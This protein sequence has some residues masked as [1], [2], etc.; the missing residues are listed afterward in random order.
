VYHSEETEGF[1]YDCY[2][3]DGIGKR[4]HNSAF[5]SR[6]K[7]CDKSG[8]ASR[9]SLFEAL[10]PARFDG[11][12]KGGEVY[13]FLGYEYVYE[14]GEAMGKPV[15]SPLIRIMATEEEQTGNTYDSIYYN[16]H[17]DNGC[18]LSQLVAHGMVVNKEKILL[19]WQGEIVISTASAASKDGGLE[20]FV[21]FDESHRYNNNAL[22]VMHGVVTNNVTKRRA[23]GSWYLETT[24]MFASGEDSIAEK[25]YDYMG[26]ILEG[27]AKRPK[28]LFDH[29]WG[30]ITDAEMAD[31][32]LL[33]AALI[34]SY[35][36]VALLYDEDGNKIGAGWVDVENIIDDIYTPVNEDAKNPRRFF[37]N[38]P[39][40]QSGNSW[41]QPAELEKVLTRRPVEKGDVITLGFDGSL[42]KDA[43]VLMGCRVSDNY[44]F[45]IYY[46][47]RPD[48]PEAEGWQVDVAAFEGKVDE[49]FRNYRVVGF[50]AD[51]AHW[52]DSIVKWEQKY[53]QYLK[54]TAS[55]KDPIKFY[56]TYPTQ[57]IRALD[58]LKTAI[59][60]CNVAIE[61]NKF[62]KRQ[63]LN[64]IMRE[65][66]SGVLVYKITPKSPRTIDTIY[67]ATFAHE[68]AARFRGTNNP[69]KP[70][71]KPVRR[72]LPARLN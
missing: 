23:E 58:G 21:V 32:V 55:E 42:V 71:K 7:G 22:R 38:A 19:P 59:L 29:R 57:M 61:N 20:T 39:S 60:T 34:D 40:A 4:M 45:P 11:W 26:L 6:P 37:L 62:T 31:E 43:T 53:G 1:L 30:E 33:R 70:K 2:A 64:G 5:Y 48:G 35:G 16:L 51:P 52:R 54:I 3:I 15:A 72:Q 10:G 63:M 36:E 67:A 56:S 50:F 9:I 18:I 8:L 41:L 17:P 27:K 44:L 13:E 46:E 25:Q 65:R 14:P 68:A 69:F 24:T 12:A 28:M 49:A 66:D 47:E